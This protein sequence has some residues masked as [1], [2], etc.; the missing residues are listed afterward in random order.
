MFDYLAMW[1]TQRTGRNT[2][3]TAPVWAYV[4]GVMVILGC[5]PALWSNPALRTL[6]VA[7]ALAL[8]IPWW[9]GRNR[10]KV[11]RAEARE[12]KRL[13]A[14]EAMELLRKDVA[15]TEAARVAELQRLRNKY[16][17]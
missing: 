17:A 12:H 7:L 1:I 15:E 3:V 5:I 9:M 14:V 8:V 16:R 10:T 4:L 11:Q 6:L 13:A 2:A